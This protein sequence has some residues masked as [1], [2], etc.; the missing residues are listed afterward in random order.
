MGSAA[1]RWWGGGTVVQRARCQLPA[2]PRRHDPVHTEA[3]LRPPTARDRGRADGPRAADN[4]RTV[5]AE[6]STGTWSITVQPDGD[7]TIALP[8][9]AACD[10]PGAE[11]TAD[12]QRL[13][14]LADCSG[15]QSLQATY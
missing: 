11:C 6:G 14:N 3:E 7:I 1:D 4:R 15:Q 12:G 2:P 8:A 9:E 13:H 10:Q 5:A